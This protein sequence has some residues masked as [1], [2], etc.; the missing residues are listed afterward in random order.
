M[1]TGPIEAI[2]GD[3]GKAFR[4]CRFYP[5]THPSVQQALASLS[6]SLPSL[7]RIG[8]IELRLQPAGMILGAAPLAPRN[9]QIQEL[10][11]LLYTQGHRS[12]TLEPGL[13]SDEVAALIRSAASGT[14]RV[15]QTVGGEAEFERLPHIRLERTAK[16]AQRHTA[17]QRTSSDVESPTLSRRSSGVFR[18]DA[19]P[20][21]I[22]ATRLAAQIDK[23]DGDLVPAIARIGVLIG[24][25]AA[26]R[27]FRHMTVAVRSLARVSAHA[28]AA[29]AKAATA[30]L[31]ER[32][33]PAALSGLLGRLH[34]AGVTPEERDVAVQA[35]GALGGR[36]IPGV[37][38]AC[39]VAGSSEE[40]DILLAVV[41]RA[42]PQAADAIL[43]RMDPD[44]RGEMARVNALL[45]GATRAPEVAL[46]LGAL[47][48]HAEA[49]VRRS[50][51]DAL[52]H[53]DDP[54]AVRH[55]FGALRDGDATVRASAARGIGWAGDVAQVP[56][57]IAKL[58]DEADDEAAVAMIEAL[59]ELRD[60]RAVPLLESLARGVAGVFQR[61][62][63]AVR[64]AATAALESLKA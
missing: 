61:H 51:V 45:L 47:A 6:A 48:M 28:D 36:A 33:T 41:R 17:P 3:I 46:M 37:F 64:A 2:L 21:E 53:I 34:D 59:V 49:P 60:P 56:L 12:L 26:L 44:A 8:A 52:A 63:P 4:L 7:A 62:A 5:A 13:T 9:T 42:G 24:E 54:E 38:D 40:R 32:I 57:L 27:D 22:E 25:L 43:A 15:M 58:K 1:D 14:E 39:H 11:R 23:G 18:P 30:Q 35:L 29:I 20:P 16:K 50:A 19:L 10:A 55:L 31:D